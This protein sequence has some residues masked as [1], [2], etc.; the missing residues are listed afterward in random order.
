M[1]EHVTQNAE[2]RREYARLPLGVPALLETLEGRL[3]VRIV[4]ISQG[5]A[6]IVLPSKESFARDC[7]LKWLSFEA[8]G[9]VSWRKDAQIGLTFDEP[10]SHRTIFETR[11]NSAQLF[12]QEAAETVNEARNWAQGT[13]RL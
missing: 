5:G 1:T 7:L 9:A 2:S 4:D 10:L 8:F 12:R 3:R 13:M 11:Q 6:Q